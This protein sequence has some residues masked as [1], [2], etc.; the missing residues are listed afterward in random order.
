MGQFGVAIIEAD[1]QFGRPLAKFLAD[2][3]FLPELHQDAVA[4]FPRLATRP[5]QAVLLGCEGEPS[6][7][8]QTLRRIREMSIVPCLILS[9]QADDISEILALEA[10]ADGLLDRATPHRALLARLTAV[11]RRG[12]W[13]AVETVPALS[14]GGWK[15]IPERRQ[16]LRPDGSECAL[17][18]AEFDLMQI[19]AESMGKP[20]SRDLIAARVFKRPFRAE[21]RTVDNLVLRLRR[22]L[23]PTQQDSIKTIRG[24]GYL[25]AGFIGSATRVAVA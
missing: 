17:T 2:H 4:L 16:L 12:D 22:K 1:G 8:L 3:G 23:G 15:L 14:V 18:T 11:L 10:G 13:G 9:G 21:D 20:V 24:A 7:T 6:A 19:L 25:F 5:P